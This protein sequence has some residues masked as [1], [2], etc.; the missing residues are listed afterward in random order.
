MKKFIK[1]MSLV[2]AVI[3]M[4]SCFASCGA[5][6]RCDDFKMIVVDFGNDHRYVCGKTVRRVVGYDGN[7]RFCVPFFQGF[8]CHEQP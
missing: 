5:S 2:L 7:F 1:L 8:G 3:M 4:V 6:L